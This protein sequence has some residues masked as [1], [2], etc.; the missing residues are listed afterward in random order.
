MKAIQVSRSSV[1]G[2]LRAKAEGV[3]AII[4]SKET[5]DD[6]N[7]A[8]DIATRLCAEYNWLQDGKFRLEEG[9]LPN[10]DTV[11]VFVKNEVEPKPDIRRDLR[12][13]LEKYDA[14]LVAMDYTYPDFESI[15]ISI[16]TVKDYKPILEF[17]T[18]E[19][20]IDSTHYLLSEEV[21]ANEN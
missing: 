2:K 13:L 4:R 11:F 9:G 1:T 5:L 19:T 18:D 10:G 17:G 8:L 21:I 14:R 12:L 20:I 6:N 3:P 16:R 7:P 15:Q